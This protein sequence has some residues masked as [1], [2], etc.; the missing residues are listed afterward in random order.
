MFDEVIKHIKTH[1]P[2]GFIPLHAP[3]F[4]GNEKEYLNE[5]I[6]ST[7]VSSVGK[8]VNRFEEMMQEISGAKYAVATVNGTSALHI[9]LHVLGVGYEDEVITQPLTFVATCNA[10][11]YTGANPVF[12]DVDL[13]TMGMSPESLKNFLEANCSKKDNQCINK[14]TGKI[15]K[16][17]VPMHTFGFPCLIAEIVEICNKWNIPVVEDAAE[18]LGSYVGEKHTGTF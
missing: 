17:C 6:D 10:I 13:D 4:V 14:S 7:F 5:C 1:F 8:F 18:S 15:I 11:K 9:A 16:A 12:V 3:V 2:K